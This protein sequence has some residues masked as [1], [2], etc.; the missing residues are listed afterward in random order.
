M[1]KSFGSLDRNLEANKII[2]NSK[3]I[4]GILKD[5]VFSGV[6]EFE[7]SIKIASRSVI[8]IGCI[9]TYQLT[10]SLEYILTK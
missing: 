9:I 1:I 4:S 5:L 3:P 10:S 2:T 8:T 7:S 6:P